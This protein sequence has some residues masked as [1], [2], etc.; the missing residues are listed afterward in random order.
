M[1]E[2]MTEERLQTCVECLRRY[3]THQGVLC[4]FGWVEEMADEIKRCWKVIDRA[5]NTY[6]RWKRPEGMGRIV[7]KLEE[8]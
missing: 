6:K 4:A 8:K 7:K 2:P 1:T 3:H 5:K